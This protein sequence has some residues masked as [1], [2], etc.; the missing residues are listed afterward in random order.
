M[1]RHGLC[2]VRL[3]FPFQ[4]G[5]VSRGSFAETNMKHG[6]TKTKSKT[7]LLIVILKLKQRRYGSFIHWMMLALRLSGAMLSDCVAALRSR[8][9]VTLHSHG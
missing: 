6:K 2:N 9:T 5:T 7:K 4:Y 3:H 1:Y 8:W